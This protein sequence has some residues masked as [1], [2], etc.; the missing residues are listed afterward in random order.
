MST[1]QERA[2]KW[3][4]SDDTGSS[5]E[6]IMKHMLSISDKCYS[7]PSDVSDLGRCLRLLKLFPEWKL[8]ISEMAQ[9][10]PGWAGQ[11]AVWNKLEALMIEECGIDWSKAKRAPE[12]YKA[13]KLAQA[14]GYRNDKRYRCTFAKDGTLSSAFMIDE[15]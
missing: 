14:N 9:Y 13:M 6:A 11:V 8:R 10:S 4:F 1:T 5:S 3:L 7:Y 12:T 2:M 15:D